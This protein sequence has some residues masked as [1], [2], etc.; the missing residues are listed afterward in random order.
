MFFHFSKNFGIFS[1]IFGRTAVSAFTDRGQ[2]VH[3]PRSMRSLTAV[4]AFTDRTDCTKCKNIRVG[5]PKNFSKITKH[6]I[7][8]FQVKQTV[9]GYH[10]YV[11]WKTGICLVTTMYYSF[12]AFWRSKRIKMCPKCT[13][14]AI[15]VLQTPWKQIKSLFRVKNNQFLGSKNRKSK[16][17]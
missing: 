8:Y 6:N 2:C 1:W 14:N 5:D 9:F 16:R 13:L 17:L 10:K 7:S 3:W 4:R 12:K 15:S 11:F